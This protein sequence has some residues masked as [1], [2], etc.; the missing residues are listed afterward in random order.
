MRLTI[1][2]A[3]SVYKNAPPF[4]S[5]LYMAGSVRGWDIVGSYRVLVT[6]FLPKKSTGPLVKVRGLSRHLA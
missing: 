4:A 1:L 3:F 2:R 6:G 5:Q